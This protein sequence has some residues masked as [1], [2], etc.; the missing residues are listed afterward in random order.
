MAAPAAA[1]FI[2]ARRVNRTVSFA[3][4]NLIVFFSLLLA[5]RA[6]GLERLRGFP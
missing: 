5:R 1:I 6:D 2:N 4:S 3:W